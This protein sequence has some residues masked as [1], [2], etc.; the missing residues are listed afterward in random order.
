MHGARFTRCSHADKARA[1]TSVLLVSGTSTI[2]TRFCQPNHITNHN[3]QRNTTTDHPSVCLS[4]VLLLLFPTIMN[5]TSALLS[6]MMMWF[7]TIVFI[8]FLETAE[9][10][11]VQQIHSKAASTTQRSN[12]AVLFAV[13]RDS[14]ESSLSSSP[15]SQRRRHP[16]QPQDNVQDRSNPDKRQRSHAFNTRNRRH[17]PRD[18]RVKKWI[19]TNKEIT[20]CDSADEVLSVLSSTPSALAKLAGLSAELRRWELP[21]V[22]LP[23]RTT[24]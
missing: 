24:K 8:I 17:S 2:T 21:A 3:N 5:R 20:Q 22:P 16:K 1:R 9:A 10:F 23:K 14:S 11:S 13:S 7:T 4:F 18:P 15:R 19:A 12:K 6:L